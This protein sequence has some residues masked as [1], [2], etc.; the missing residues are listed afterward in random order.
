[1][2]GKQDKASRRLTKAVDEKMKKHLKSL[3]GAKKID[4]AEVIATYN[5]YLRTMSF[6]KKWAFATSLLFSGIKQKCLNIILF[7]K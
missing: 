5:H 6:K 2:S 7:W 4:H 3:E 1:M